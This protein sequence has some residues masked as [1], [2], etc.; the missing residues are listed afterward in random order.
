MFL[1]NAADE[2]ARL[3]FSQLIYVLK[4]K[5]QSLSFCTFGMGSTKAE[6]EDCMSEPNQFSRTFSLALSELGIG[7]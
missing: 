5:H 7:K 4:K 6:G 2:Q 3:K 1:H